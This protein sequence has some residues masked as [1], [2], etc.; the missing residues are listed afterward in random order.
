MP[1]V[2]QPPTT[3]EPRAGR[4]CSSGPQR[5]RVGER[6]GLPVLL[7]ATALLYL[8]G[9]AGIDLWT[10][11]EPRYAAIAEELRSFRHGLDG[12]VLLHLNDEVY[13]QKPPLYFWLAALFG[14]PGGRVD[15]LAARLPSAL[16]GLAAV[17]MTALLGRRMLVR[18]W[19]AL[20]AG[21]LLA[22]SFRFAFTARRAQLDVLL[23]AFE[24]AAI[25]LFWRLETATGG[26][27]NARR[28]P[29]V[30]AALHASLGAAALVKGPVGW[31]PL[32][33][34]GVFLVWEGRGR[35]FRE[36]VPWWAWSLSLG[37]LVAWSATAV[38]LAPPGF[39]EIA[40]GENLLGR[41]FEGTSH[42]RPL[43]YYLY[44]LPL[45]FLPWT[46]LLPTAIPILLRAARE[47][48]A[49][50]GDERRP[51]SPRTARFLTA[52]VGVPLLFFSLSA[53]KRGVYLLPVFPALAL[54]ATLALARA[55]RRV[56]S[57]ER[58]GAIALVCVALLEM[59]IAQSVF[60]RLDSEKS[61]RPI[62]QTVAAA[63]GPDESVGVYGL[64]PIEGSLG[65]YAGV[66]VTS[67][68]TLAALE[69]Y[70]A[71]GG[72][73]V[74]LRE[75]DL[76]AHGRRLDLREIAGMRSGRRRL[77]L[78]GAAERSSLGEDGNSG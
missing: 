10:P 40:I 41:F 77:I 39:A 63:A 45:D 1:A 67:L 3:D 50:G 31:L 17:A 49:R 34:F 48:P 29:G 64:S 11:D 12:L 14:A 70:L 44:Q 35:A 38:A 33:V 69:R 57:P 51:V 7:A 8:A 15:E 5:E 47:R 72:R 55:P 20:L 26:T 56:R 46:L 58:A 61:L 19:A 13:T 59:L 36:I 53:G 54:L 4:A 23:T 76:E 68:R 62:A 78:A 28:S 42:A 73:L 25:V 52:W 43:Y 27:G 21:G 9:L 2:H 18:P 37:P 75:R 32:A 16:A 60:P 6:I 65:Y 74:L 24:L 30:I 66:R 71:A 22:T